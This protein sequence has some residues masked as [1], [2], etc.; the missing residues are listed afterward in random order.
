VSTA[1]D[2]TPVAA[3]GRRIE[4]IRDEWRVDE[5]WWS[6]NRIRRRYFD[7]VLDDGRNTIV[8]WDAQRRRW[9][10]QRA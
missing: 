5:G 8:F 7:L 4:H 9:Y 3:G 2:G 1:G 10:S 6:G